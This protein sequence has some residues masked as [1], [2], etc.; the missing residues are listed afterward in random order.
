MPQRQPYLPYPD[1][2]HRG[3]SGKVTW[4]RISNRLPPGVLLCH[5]AMVSGWLLRAELVMTSVGS[6]QLRVN[7]ENHG[8]PMMDCTMSQ[9]RKHYQSL[10]RQLSR[11]RQLLLPL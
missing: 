6:L 1:R 9:G 2:P 7:G 4:T 10:L 5:E 8:A 11:P 3:A